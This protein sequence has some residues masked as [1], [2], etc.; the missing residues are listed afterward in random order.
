MRDS[1][2]RVKLTPEIVRNL[3]A[4][5]G[6]SRESEQVRKEPLASWDSAAVH[7]ERIADRLV[8]TAGKVIGVCALAMVV[9]DWGNSESL[10][11]LLRYI[12]NGPSGI[13]AP[14]AAIV[15]LL[16][17]AWLRSRTRDE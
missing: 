9:F 6:V 15:F 5:D 14:I 11:D 7:I 8:R 17:R 10:V 16:G 1:D 3:D 12:A 4:S 2:D 13:V